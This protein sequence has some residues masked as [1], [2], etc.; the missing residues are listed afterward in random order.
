[1]FV[2]GRVIMHRITPSGEE[3]YIGKGALAG[4]SKGQ[5]RAA[6]WDLPVVPALQLGGRMRQ[7]GQQ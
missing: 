3:G 6:G 4:G 5:A 2:V 7:A 1:M